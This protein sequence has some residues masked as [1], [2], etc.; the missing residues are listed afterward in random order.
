[1]NQGLFSELS[2]ATIT[3]L[4]LQLN[5]IGSHSTRAVDEGVGVNWEHAIL[6]DYASGSV[7]IENVTIKGSM[8]GTAQD[9]SD[10][11]N[12]WMGMGINAGMGAA[13][14]LP[15]MFNK[16]FGG[17]K[18]FAGA[19]NGLY[20]GGMGAVFSG[21][22]ALASYYDYKTYLYCAAGIG[23]A[24]SGS[25][26][27]F[28]NVA[29]SAT[30]DVDGY[31]LHYAAGLIAQA[32]GSQIDFTNC[33]NDANVTTSAGTSR[34]ANQFMGCLKSVAKIIGSALVKNGVVGYTSKGKLTGEV[35]TDTAK[36]RDAE[37]L[38]DLNNAFKGVDKDTIKAIEESDAFKNAYDSVI[39]PENI[40]D[41][42]GE[43]SDDDIFQARQ[44]AYLKGLEEVQAKDPS[45]LFT[46]CG[47]TYMQ[48]EYRGFA[49]NF[50]AQVMGSFWKH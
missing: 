32:D 10:T 20:A 14:L 25:H 21:I 2:N 45:K 48:A 27:T 47:I 35:G 18:G 34:L 15:D 24:K 7:T 42:F 11:A 33:T 3:N 6:A 9:Y 1:M 22:G 44:L 46:W 5:V 12:T 40:S 23:K 17:G 16:I 28:N 30:V 49:S 13:A 26:I 29:N 8:L 38:E 39:P 50:N 37:N 41:L 43:L 31:G 36:I 4:N 19:N